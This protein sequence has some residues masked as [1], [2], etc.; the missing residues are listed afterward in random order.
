M[1]LKVGCSMGL[2]GCRIEDE[3]VVEDDAT[4]EDIEDAVREWALGHFEW[5]SDAR[6]PEAKP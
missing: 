4:A 1:K 5:W 6:V 2:A 3:I